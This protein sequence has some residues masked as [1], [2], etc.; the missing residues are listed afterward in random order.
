MAGIEVPAV[1]GVVEG[2]AGYLIGRFQS[3]AYQRLGAAHREGRQQVPLHS[4]GQGHGSAAPA[5]VHQIGGPGEAANQ[6]PGELPETD[7]VSE[8]GLVHDWQRQ[9]HHTGTFASFDERYPHAYGSIPSGRHRFP[10]AKGPAGHGGRDLLLGQDRLGEVG[11]QQDGLQHH[12]PVVRQVQVH[13]AGADL[14]GGCQ[15]QP[16]KIASRRIRD[17]VQRGGVVQ[18]GRPVSLAPSGPERPVDGRANPN[19]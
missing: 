13:L 9:C 1:D 4:R 16:G 14:A 12:S 11:T 5:Q 7:A 18:R 2:V 6:Q 10:G 8:H 15:Q 19:P 3:A 17:H